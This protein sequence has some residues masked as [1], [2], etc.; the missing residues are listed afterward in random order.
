MLVDAHCHYSNDKSGDNVLALSN[1]SKWNEGEQPAGGMGI[2]P[3]YS[4]LYSIDEVKDKIEFYREMLQW[5]GS[6]S[7][8]LEEREAQFQELVAKLPNPTT[9][10]PSLPYKPQFIGEVGVDKSFRIPVTYFTVSLSHQLEILD[11]WLCQASEFSIPIQLHCVKYHDHLL[12]HCV[13]H[14]QKN[15]NVNI[16]L[17]GF[18]G[19][20]EMLTQW[21]KRFPDGRLFVSFNIHLNERCVERYASVLPIESVLVESDHGTFSDEVLADLKKISESVS[22]Y[23]NNVNYESNIER[24]LNKE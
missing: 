12:Q 17:H 9:L 4:H 20:E 16:L 8:S 3:W 23:Y 18:Q 6:K 14:L 19:S 5:V 21:F 2:H 13:Q 11:W 7:V 1:S 22:G 24:F 10:P 15:K